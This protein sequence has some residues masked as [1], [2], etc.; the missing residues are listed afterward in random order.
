MRIIAVGV[1]A[2]VISMG[3]AEP[4]LKDSGRQP[5]STENLA[6]VIEATVSNA[7][8]LGLACKIYSMDH[9]GAYPPSLTDVYP[10]YVGVKTIFVCPLCPKERVGYA[11]FGGKASDPPK[12]VLLYSKAPIPDGEWVVIYND[13]TFELVSKEP[14]R[15]ETPTEEPGPK[16]TPK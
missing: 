6:D 2:V 3:R 8:Q 5:G 16:E 12:Q 14:K 9:G 13:L 15:P 7:R 1:L 11:Y 4:P 10:D